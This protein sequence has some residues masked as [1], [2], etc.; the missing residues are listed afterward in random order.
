MTNSLAIQTGP[1]VGMSI[2]CR[3]MIQKI[4]ATQSGI[5]PI[6]GGENHIYKYFNQSSIKHRFHHTQKPDRD[7]THVIER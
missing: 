7:D 4:D 3:F 6:V 5:I 2:I 1:R